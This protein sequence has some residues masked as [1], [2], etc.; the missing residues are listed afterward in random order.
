MSQPSIAFNG[1]ASDTFF[2]MIEQDHYTQDQLD[3]LFGQSPSDQPVFSTANSEVLD[4]LDFT[5][6]DAVLS[7]ANA[8]NNSTIST[9]DFSSYNFGQQNPTYPS[10]PGATSPHPYPLE[11]HQRSYLQ[12]PRSLPIRAQT[13][14]SFL[15]P[16]QPPQGY[17]RRRSLSTNDADR[18][19]NPTFVRLQAPRARSTTPEEKRRAGPYPR[20]GRSASQPRG[21][22][23]KNVGMGYMPNMQGS[24]LGGG[25]TTIGTPMCEESEMEGMGR[26]MYGRGEAMVGMQYERHEDPIMTRMTDPTQLAHS[27]RVIQIGAMAVRNHIPLPL[28]IDPRFNSHESMLKKLEDVERHLKVQDADNEEALRGCE[29]IREALGKRVNVLDSPIEENGLEKPSTVMENGDEEKLFGVGFDEE[30]LMG[31]LVRENERCDEE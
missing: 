17:I 14:S 30:G 19:P 20:H 31:L 29:M 8:S 11:H 13:N 7:H 23:L 6:D 10:H 5:F 21:R 27:R 28:A 4:D 2:P 16:S 18:I 26:S 1:A 15:L 25:M 12:P 22:P 3:E 9:P 24:P